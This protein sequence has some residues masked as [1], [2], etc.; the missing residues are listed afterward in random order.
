MLFGRLLLSLFGTL[1]YTL[2][3]CIL[4]LT[5]G[6]ILVCSDLKSILL[7]LVAWAAHFIAVKP[8]LRFPWNEALTGTEYGGWEREGMQ[9]GDDG[10]GATGELAVCCSTWVLFYSANHLLYWHF[11]LGLAYL[12]LLCHLLL[13]IQWRGG[14]ST[15]GAF[16]SML[17]D[18]S[19]GPHNRAGAAI[20]VPSLSS[21]KWSSCPTLPRTYSLFNFQVGSI[22]FPTHTTHTCT[23]RSRPTPAGKYINGVF[24]SLPLGSLR[25]SHSISWYMDWGMKCSST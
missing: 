16:R 9:E 4:L 18:H 25:K 8:S 6:Y 3:H 2:I 14:V 1:W 23:R 12:H 22:R 24:L 20:F 7:A 15:R 11:V 13:L 19:S 21:S 10:W 5:S 17:P